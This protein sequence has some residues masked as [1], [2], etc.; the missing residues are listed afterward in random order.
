M[1]LTAVEVAWHHTSDPALSIHIH[2]FFPVLPLI[3]NPVSR[4]AGKILQ[5]S[6][7]SVEP[8]LR[9]LVAF[10]FSTVLAALAIIY[11]FP[12]PCHT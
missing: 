2:G 11:V 9:N 8:K 1:L 4:L 5:P 10:C 12:W 3:F 7:K 6:L